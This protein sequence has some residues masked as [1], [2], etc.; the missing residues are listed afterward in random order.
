MKKKKPKKT[1]M[2]VIIVIVI[3]TLLFCFLLFDTT[4]LYDVDISNFYNISNE[5]HLPISVSEVARAVD[6]G[7][8]GDQTST[9]DTE[10][11][12][13]GGTEPNPPMPG[14]EPP[15]PPSDTS[16]S[17]I[18]ADIAKGLY[19]QEDYD[20][21]VALGGEAT[22]YDGFYAVACSV[23]NRV[24]A[25]N[26]SYK[27]IVTS[28]GQYTGY[29]SSEIGKPKNDDIKKAAIAVLRGGDS[30]VGDYQNFFGR[31]GSHDIWYEA[32]KC[33]KN[34]PIVIGTGAYRNVF[35]SKWGDCHNA[36]DTK[37]NDAVT[38]YSAS[39]KKWYVN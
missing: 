14:T 9:G 30:T 13:P 31:S 39:E 22:T 8:A 1:I 6:E 21:L 12:M 28:P 2:Y 35:Y 26:S 11:P 18:D 3:L 25:N 38:L 23:R 33:G 36:L 7:N 27:A 10:V 19:T 20:Y 32:N 37:T 34:I 24:R 15:T 5:L 16:D 29:N 17:D 4:A